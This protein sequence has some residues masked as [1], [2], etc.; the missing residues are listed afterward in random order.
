MS[1]LKDY[2][3]SRFP[4]KK[5]GKLVIELLKI[6]E[7]KGFEPIP[8]SFTSHKCRKYGNG[9]FA[10]SVSSAG[11]PSMI[12][13]IFM[14]RDCVKFGKIGKLEFSKQEGY[15]EVFLSGLYRRDDD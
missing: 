10:W 11:N 6:L 12:G 13:S 14:V 1:E 9:E 2:I 8:N 7:D 5:H 15:L 4:E 3:N